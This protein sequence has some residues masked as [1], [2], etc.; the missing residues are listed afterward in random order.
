MKAFILSLKT[1]ICADDTFPAIRN[2]AEILKRDM[3]ERLTGSGPENMIR[4]EL[5]TGMAAETY[6]AEVKSDEI[7]L[8]CGDDLGAVFRQRTA[9]EG[10]AA[11]LV[12]GDEAGPVPDR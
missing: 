10:Q 5:D 4:V 7:R 6:R 1:K 12:D 11:G 3:A 2:A 8:T 9:A